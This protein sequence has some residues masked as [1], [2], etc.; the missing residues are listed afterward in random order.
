[1]TRGF[2]VVHLVWAVIATW[3]IG[4]VVLAIV[5]PDALR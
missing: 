5:A 4:Y 1:M 3:A 2:T